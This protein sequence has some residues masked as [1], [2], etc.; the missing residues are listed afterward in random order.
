MAFFY[1][2]LVLVC[3][4]LDGQGGSTAAGGFGRAGSGT[5]GLGIGRGSGVA[6]RRAGRGSGGYGEARRNFDQQSASAG[7]GREERE[8]LSESGREGADLGRSTYREGRGE[9]DARG[10]KGASTAL[11]ISH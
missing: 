7:R 5:W 8:S 2:D 3:R 6:A 1:L 9:R 10:G 11:S 4:E